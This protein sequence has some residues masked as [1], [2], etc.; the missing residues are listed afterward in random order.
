MDIQEDAPEQQA[1]QLESEPPYAKGC[2]APNNQN[3]IW[4]KLTYL[5]QLNWPVELCP[6][7]ELSGSPSASLHSCSLPCAAT[8]CLV[9]LRPGAHQAEHCLKGGSSGASSPA[10][11]PCGAG[12]WQWWHGTAWVARRGD[13]AV[14]AA[15]SG[16]SSSRWRAA[17]SSQAPLALSGCFVKGGSGFSN[18]NDKTLRRVAGCTH[19]SMEPR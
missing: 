6:A 14:V 11:A 2:V 13:G 16:T 8:G 3:L 4:L 9:T 10:P 15:P 12:R 19:Q 18:P 5:H 1:S 7:G 17:P